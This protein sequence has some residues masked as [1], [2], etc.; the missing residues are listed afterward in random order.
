[1][2]EPTWTEIKTVRVP[3]RQGC[4]W[5]RALDW[6][7]PSKLYRIEVKPRPM[8]VEGPVLAEGVAQAGTHPA[9]VAVPPGVV[10]PP[11]PA[12]GPPGAA[13]PPAPAAGPPAVVAPPAPAAGP[14]AVVAPPVPAAGPPAVVAP[15]APVAV[16]PGVVAPPAPAPVQPGAD[17]E[18]VIEDQTWTP[19]GSNQ[20]CSADGDFGGLSRREALTVPGARLGTL[21]GK[22]GGSTGDQVL[23]PTIVSVFPVGR[24]CV[25]K[26]PDETKTGPLYLS[27]NDT[28]SGA[29]QV[30]GF[31][32]VVISEAL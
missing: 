4:V 18:P 5:T 13:A 26:S 32:Q 29:T 9:P 23:D 27:I 2:G 19:L 17:A 14:P 24:F 1:M 25:F 31:L 3:E 28:A 15:P 10:A 16:A 12:A 21:I 8:Q 22:I 7:T 6:L 11:V 30:E 20:A